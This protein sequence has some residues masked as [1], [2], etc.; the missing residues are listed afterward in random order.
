MGGA[1]HDVH[2]KVLLLFIWNNN[3]DIVG[4]M[5]YITYYQREP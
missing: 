5:V 2:P 3:F 4:D 1:R